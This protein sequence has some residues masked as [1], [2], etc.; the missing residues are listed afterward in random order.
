MKKVIAILT[1]AVI[2]ATVMAAC[3]KFTCDLCEKEKSGKKHKETYLGQDIVICDDCYDDL[4]D[5]AKAFS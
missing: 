5:L 2:I 3:G 4:E 1:L